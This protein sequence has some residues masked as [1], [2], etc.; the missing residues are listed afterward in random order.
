LFFALRSC[1]LVSALALVAGCGSEV[2]SPPAAAPSGSTLWGRRFGR[3]SD[4]E[5]VGISA[6]PSGGVIVAGR[7]YGDVDFGGGTQPSPNNSYQVFVAR[8]DETGKHVYSKTFGAEYGE[9]AVDVA[10]LP[11]G[12]ALV[13]GE[14]GF[15]VD[16]GQG[17]LTSAGSDDIFVL[18][19]D[20]SGEVAWAKRY[21]GTGNQR[22]MAIA[23]APD[24][25]AAIG[26]ETS[27]GI[28]L[29]VGAQED[30]SSGG[31][32]LR[33]DSK[34]D[35]V[36]ARLDG[37]NSY[38]PIADIVVKPSGEVAVGGQFYETIDLGGPSP[39]VADGFGDGFVAIY[40]ADGK[41]VWS[42]KVGG[43]GSGDTVETRWRRSP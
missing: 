17:V 13:V 25:G 38:R 3:A 33:I 18:K 7:Y 22:A 37:G 19:L 35:I 39:L 26:G 5:P 42:R 34:G 1:F 9:W 11:D 41:Y 15:E 12:S 21:G 29:G 16:F 6:V 23:A 10:A 30:A 27:G 40:G 20:P 14:F 28:D 36:W 2:E 8:Y 4:V 31:F 32:I 43:F 24:G